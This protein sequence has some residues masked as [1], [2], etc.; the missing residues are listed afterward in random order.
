MIDSRIL[1]KTA[2]TSP[3]SIVAL[4]DTEPKRKLFFLHAGSHGSFGV[5]PTP[6]LR[7]STQRGRPVAAHLRS[8]LVRRQPRENHEVTRSPCCQI[9]VALPLRRSS[10]EVW[11][12][13]EAISTSPHR[14]AGDSCDDNPSLAHRDFAYAA[15]RAMHDR[16]LIATSST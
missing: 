7:F 9:Y 4:S 13:G 3:V 6:G 1:R 14:V 8:A 16:A 5:N 2:L 12:R 11:R 10:K 15:Q